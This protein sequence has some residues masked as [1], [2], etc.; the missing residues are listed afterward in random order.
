SWNC[1]NLQPRNTFHA[2]AADRHKFEM[3]APHTDNDLVDFLL[4]IPPSARLEQRVYKK[5]I[6]YSFPEIRTVTC[7]NSGQ[8]IDPNFAR[9]YSK[10]VARF[11]AVRMT[12]PFRKLV[13]KR[14]PLGREFRNLGEDFRAEPELMD[15]IL[16][17]LLRAGVL[18]ESIFNYS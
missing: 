5:M 13:S 8:P 17:P 16:K 2:P 9:E 1:V 15:G 4:T 18:P 3:R 11:V 6:A 7:T 10:M 12:A 14:Q